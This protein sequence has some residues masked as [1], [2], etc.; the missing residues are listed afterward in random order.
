MISITDVTNRDR[1][2]AMAAVLD[3]YAR[4]E[5]IRRAGECVSYSPREFGMISSYLRHVKVTIVNDRH[6]RVTGPAWRTYTWVHARITA[7]IDTAANALTGTP[8]E[9]SFDD[10]RIDTEAQNVERFTW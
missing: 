4:G 6:I 3:G 8:F 9:I 10:C 2:E 7:L 5:M 1:A